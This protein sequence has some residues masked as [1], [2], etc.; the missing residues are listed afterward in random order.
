MLEVR[1]NGGE[2]RIRVSYQMSAIVFET[3]LPI[4]DH[5]RIAMAW[6]NDPVTLSMSFHRREKIWESFWPEYR[7]TYFSGAPDLHPV[8]AVLD[9]ERIG[10]LRFNPVP[11]PSGLPHRTVDLSIN[12]S[13]SGAARDWA[14][15]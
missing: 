3:C 11:H 9:G 6:R 10:F 5:A 1:R 4:E 12:I 8:F 13:P 7:T 14:G 2:E 15:R